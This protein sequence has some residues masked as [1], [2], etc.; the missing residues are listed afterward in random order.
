M[1]CFLLLIFF[2]LTFA[3]LS[4]FSVSLFFHHSF[5]VQWWS[6]VEDDLQWP[7][8]SGIVSE[9]SCQHLSLPFSLSLPPHTSYPC[10]QLH[11][12][13]TKNGIEP[14]P[15]EDENCT[16][17]EVT[18]EEVEN[19]VKHI[20]SLATVVSG[21]RISRPAVDTLPAFREC[22]SDVF[23]IGSNFSLSFALKPRGLTKSFK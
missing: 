14:L 22:R 12:W 13:V 15:T 2:F 17:I 5:W 18:E 4:R 11:P 8:L 3:S 23:Q 19:S 1:F 16:L 21:L 9:M 7:N 6:Y 20:P 10:P